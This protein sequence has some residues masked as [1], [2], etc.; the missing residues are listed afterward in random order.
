MPINYLDIAMPVALKSNQTADAGDAAALE[1]AYQGGLASLDGTDI[2]LSALKQAVLAS[3]QRIAGF[4]SKLEDPAMRRQL[5]GISQALAHGALLPKQDA[6]G[7]EFLSYGAV[8]DAS[9]GITPLTEDSVQTIRRL[10]GLTG[11]LKMSHKYYCF[12]DGRIEHT[13]TG[14]VFV[15]GCKWDYATQAGIYGTTAAG[16]SP[17]PQECKI[18]WIADVLRNAQQEGWLGEISGSYAQIVAAEE[19]RISRGIV[20]QPKMPDNTASPDPVS[21]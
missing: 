21:N 10:R 15:E 5:Y 17:L 8:V 12:W 14:N 19:A 2:P 7:H 20:Q 6:V 3:E 1:T 13:L 11:F 9:D 16:Q 4:V 18:L